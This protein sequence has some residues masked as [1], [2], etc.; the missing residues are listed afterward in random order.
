M[1]IRTVNYTINGITPILLN[2]PQ[3]VDRFNKYSKRMAV[4][5]AKKARRTDEDYMELREIEIRSKI[6]FN[7]DGIY[8][9]ATWM[10]ASLEK[11]SHSLTKI[12]KAIMRGSVFAND[13]VMQL[14]YD[15]MSKVKTPEDVVRNDEFH[16]LMNIKQGQVRIM[17]A[18]PQFND[19]SFSG[20]LD[21]DDTLVDASD[22]ERMIKHAAR[23]GG[24]GDFRPTFGRATAEVTHVH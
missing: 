21:Y 12:P 13:T 15:G 18:Y 16:H 7:E 20:S 11:I 22:M 3:T 5:N 17:K 8:V 19:W 14:Q 23:Y 24:Y 4:I 6:Y 2:N 10:T 9:P 1:A